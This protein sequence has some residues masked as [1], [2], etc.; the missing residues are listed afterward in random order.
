MIARVAS[1]PSSMPCWVARL[2]SALD[3]RAALPNLWESMLLNNIV[4]GALWGVVCA[5]ALFAL[6]L[7]WTVGAAA[8]DGVVRTRQRPVE[9]GSMIQRLVTWAVLCLVFVPSVAATGVFLLAAFFWTAR[10]LWQ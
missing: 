7:V 10:R 3:I 4:T 6:L 8:W 9:G 1:A 5:V 2:A